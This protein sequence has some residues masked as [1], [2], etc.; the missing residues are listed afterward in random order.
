[1]DESTDDFDTNC[2]EI[3]NVISDESEDNIELN[4]Q[5]SDIEI[6]RKCVDLIFKYETDLKKIN[7]LK[8]ITSNKLSNIKQTLCILMKNN[9]VDHLNIGEQNGG[10]KIKYKKKKTYTTL[11]KK[12]LNN[13]IPLFF[14]E[15]NINIDYNL[16][17]KF[18][19]DNREF[20]ETDNLTKTK[21]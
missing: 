9:D 6:I 16:L 4:N 17:V 1:M 3:E 14:K 2:D 5:N 10:G 19:Y 21:K 7:H 20:K 12:H 8:K 13:L 15:Y 18:L 11:S